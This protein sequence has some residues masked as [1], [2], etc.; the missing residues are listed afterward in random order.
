MKEN[1]AQDNEEN[2]EDFEPE[3]QEDPSDD[4]SHG[5]SDN[6]EDGFLT[7]PDMDDFGWLLPVDAPVNWG[8]EFQWRI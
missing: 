2:R 6:E 1:Q 4:N 5:G 8:A 7:D 3:E